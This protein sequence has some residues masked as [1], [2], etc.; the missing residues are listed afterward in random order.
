MSLRAMRPWSL[1]MTDVLLTGERTWPD[2]PRENYWFMRHLACYRWAAAAIA[3]TVEDSGL[4]GGVL[5][6]GSG[7]GYGSAEL[8]RAL[9]CP[10]VAAEL[11]A[12]T[13]THS[14]A[15]YPNI[16]QVRANLVALP[17]RSGAFAASV[18]LQVIEHIWDRSTYLR[19]LDRCTRGPVVISTPNRPV[20][21]PGL[22]RGERPANPFHVL[23]FDA[24]EL[25]EML[26]DANPNRTAT[27][28][29]LRH[30]DRIRR[31]EGEYGPLPEFLLGDHVSART[32]EF[33]RTVTADDFDVVPLHEDHS[34]AQVHDLVA[35]W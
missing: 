30:G 29:G 35:L 15:H 4:D 27:I 22:A 6:A 17:F 25:A 34:S 9:A 8:T 11:D 2:V 18:S 7:E 13:A 33:A 3:E 28:V 14:R 19:E 20:H 10:V 12:S 31:W 26:D 32:W 1:D 21:S 23:E 5:D 24:V 16:A